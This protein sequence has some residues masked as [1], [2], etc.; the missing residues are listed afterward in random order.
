MRELRVVTA[1]G[2]SYFI[3]SNGNEDLKM[4]EVQ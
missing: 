4:H 2:R 1:F 3:I